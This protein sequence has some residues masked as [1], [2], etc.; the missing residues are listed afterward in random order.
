[1]VGGWLLT[2]P[3]TCRVYHQ[4]QI[5]LDKCTCRHVEAED[6]NNYNNNNNNNHHHHYHHHH[7]HRHRI[8]RRYS[9]FLTIA[10]LRRKL[11]PTRTLKRPGRSRVQI[12]CNTQSA[13]YMQHVVCHLA[14]KDSS[15]IKFD[16]VEIAFHLS[17][18]LSA[19]PLTNGDVGQTYCL[20]K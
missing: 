7:H 17:F 16:R 9:R 11:S 19:E 18:I 2:G 4:G 6:N 13:H 3:A 10:S 14:R 5:Y 8:E 1:M 12:T 15:S 20:T